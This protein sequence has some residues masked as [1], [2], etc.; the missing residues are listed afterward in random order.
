[1]S[2]NDFL[3]WMFASGGA[4][5]AA[6]WIFERV[7]WFQAQTPDLKELALFLASAV[8]SVG[9]YLVLTYIPENILVA[10]QPY[11]IMISGLFVTIIIGKMFHKVD[12]IEDDIE[13]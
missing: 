5:I 4:I 8:L 13:G 1:M 10:I 9:A 3:Q 11:F 2:I 6:S 12:K 7:A